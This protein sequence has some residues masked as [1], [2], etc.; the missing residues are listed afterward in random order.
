M[1]SFN[2]LLIAAA[3][4]TA[5]TGQVLAVDLDSDSATVSMS[6]GQF[7]SITGLDDFVLSAV[8]TDGAAGSVY[9]GSDAYNLESNAQVRV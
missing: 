5:F 6:V 1:K 4:G 8:S 3:I 9:S 7:A 2:K